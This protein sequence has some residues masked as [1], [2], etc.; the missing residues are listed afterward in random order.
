[1]IGMAVHGGAGLLPADLLDAHREGCRDA[2]RAGLDVL[3]AGGTAIDA[4]QRAVIVLEDDPTFD[5]GY[6][7]YLNRDGQVECD[8]GIMDG[9]SLA[10]GTVCAV[11]GVPNPVVLARSVLESP[12]AV[13]VGPGA[14][15][16]GVERGVPVCEPEQMVEPRVA[17]LWEELEDHGWPQGDGEAMFGDTVGAVALDQHGDL[18]AATSTGRDAGKATRPGRRL[19]VHRDRR[20]R[21]QCDRR[22]LHDRARRA[23]HSGRLGEVGGGPD[24]RRREH[25]GGRSRIDRPAGP[26]G[27]EGRH[28]HARPAGSARRRVEHAPPGVRLPG[29]GTGAVVAGPAPEGADAT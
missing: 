6:G 14:V 25:G 5:A 15:E 12:L 2:L 17:R 26:D 28:H 21:E 10:T 22:V 8:A 18:A 20:L 3:E 16:F 27:R 1:M 23:D 9:A 29:P 11:A 24:H 19:A 7:S 13:M 4:V